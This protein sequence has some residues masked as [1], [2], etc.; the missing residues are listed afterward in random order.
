M[1]ER[2]KLYGYLCNRLVKSPC[3]CIASRNN[4][5]MWFDYTRNITDKGGRVICYCNVY[6][7]QEKY[8]IVLLNTVRG[9]TSR[10]CF[11]IER[12]L[13]DRIV[14][15]GGLLHELVEIVND[16][17]LVRSYYLNSKLNNDVLAVVGYEF[18]VKE[19]GGG[20]SLE[21]TYRKEGKKVYA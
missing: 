6:D 1:K 11:E 13:F 14:A 2:E 5:V 18:E 20:L 9:A 7:K 8:R 10:T 15:N 4:G 12:V 16:H 21:C 17:S 19:H 3:V